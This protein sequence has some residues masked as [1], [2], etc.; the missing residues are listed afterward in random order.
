MFL[1]PMELTAS[2][3]I[4]VLYNILHSGVAWQQ[5]V[6]NYLFAFSSLMTYVT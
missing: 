1:E 5:T 4:S 6:G 3:K 2:F